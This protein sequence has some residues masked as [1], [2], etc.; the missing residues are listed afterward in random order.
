MKK[1]KYINKI[2][3]KEIIEHI[4][5]KDDG[6]VGKIVRDKDGEY[7][8]R[9]SLFRRMFF[10]SQTLGRGYVLKEIAERL[11]EL[12]Y[13]KCVLSDGGKQYG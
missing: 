10:L 4:Y 8:L 2:I 3:K 6:Y 9:I 7:V 12:N 11:I 1:T 13:A 5:S